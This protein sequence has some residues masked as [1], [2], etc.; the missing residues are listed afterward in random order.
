MNNSYKFLGTISAIYNWADADENYYITLAVFY[1]D[2]MD[3]KIHYNSLAYNGL[4]EKPKRGKIVLKDRNNDYYITNFNKKGD[5]K[6]MILREFLR[7]KGI[8]HYAFDI[9]Y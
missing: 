1:N 7:N 6:V 5:T 9:V 4:P 8:S 2:K 3:L